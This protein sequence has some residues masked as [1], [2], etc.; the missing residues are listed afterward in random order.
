MFTARRLCVIITIIFVY[1]PIF[2]GIIRGIMRKIITFESGLKMVLVPNNAVRSVSI[3]IFVNAGT[4]YEAKREAGISH[5]IEHMVFKGTATRSAFDI[6][7]E[8]DSIGAV[9]NAYTSKSHTCFYTTSLDTHME[10]CFDVLTDLYLNPKFD[11]TDLE[12]ERKVVFEEIN[13]S[14]D[15]P[16]DVCLEILLS[17]RFSGHPLGVP[18]LG[19]KEELS[20]LDNNDLRDYMSRR[21]TPSNT[22]V[23]FAGNIDE[24][25]CTALVNK[26]LESKLSKVASTKE[27][28]PHETK[29]SYVSRQMPISQAHIA[30][31]FPSFATGDE[32][33]YLVNLMSSVFASEMSSRLFQSIREKLGLCYTISGSSSAYEK[34]GTYIIYTA[35]S[36]ENTEKAI[37]A[38][39]KEIELLLKE[40]ITEEELQKGKEQLK[41][42]L[43]LGQESSSA[44][45]RAFGRYACIVGELYDVDRI[46]EIIDFATVESISEVCKY[47]FD[48][49]K[50]T[51]AIV[52]GNPPENPLELFK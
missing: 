32:R 37:S 11:P 35:T 18:I 48:F 47:I 4:E 31:A 16:D 30:M 51:L 15:Q 42:S 29:A 40:G 19:Y 1:A 44:M 27:H 20:A 21:Y 45:M 7:N 10:K 14:E 25:T 5:F 50:V 22:V 2:L 46:L 6:A 23:A 26:Y 38:I 28:T 33:A 34:N 39:K 41:T 12:N 43:V 17:E 9:L 24:E 36:P 49:D 8:T 3:G 52:S 13:E